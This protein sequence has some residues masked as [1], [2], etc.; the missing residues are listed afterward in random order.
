MGGVRTAVVADVLLL[1]MGGVSRSVLGVTRELGRLDPER[2]SVT[3][4]A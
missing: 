2:V 1:E 3:I 4:V